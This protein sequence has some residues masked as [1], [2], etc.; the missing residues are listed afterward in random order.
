MN[1]STII[2]GL[3]GHHGDSSGT[4]WLNW[5]EERWKEPLSFKHREDEQPSVTSQSLLVLVQD[6]EDPDCSNVRRGRLQRERKENPWIITRRL[7][8]LI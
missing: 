5:R 1:T 4:V 2:H 7:V 6:V 3:P 8:L